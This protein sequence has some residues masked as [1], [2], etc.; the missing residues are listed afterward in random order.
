MGSPDIVHLKNPTPAQLHHCIARHRPAIRPGLMDDQGATA[1][2][3]LP[4]LRAK[5]GARPVKV[6]THDQ[7][8]LYWDPR[9]GLPLRPVPFEEFARDTF[10]RGLPGYSYLQD[11][12]N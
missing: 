1:A 10:E 3:D 11:D 5:L 8:R 12:V 4:Y 9:K 2:W 7:P 6:V